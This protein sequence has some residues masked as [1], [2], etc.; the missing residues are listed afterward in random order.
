MSIQIMKTQEVQKREI[1]GSKFVFGCFI[2]SGE[3]FHPA[4]EPKIGFV[5]LPV[6]Q[7]TVNYTFQKNYNVYPFIYYISFPN[8]YRY[9]SLLLNNSLG[10]ILISL[11]KSHETEVMIL[12]YNCLL[13]TVVPIYQRIISVYHVSHKKAKQVSVK[14]QE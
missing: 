13:M 4:R 8:L 9:Q 3:C 5:E 11:A 14:R 2:V 6:H 1:L 12:I 10:T 7:G